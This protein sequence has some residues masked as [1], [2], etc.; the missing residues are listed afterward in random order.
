MVIMGIIKYTVAAFEDREVVNLSN[1]AL[2]CDAGKVPRL[3]S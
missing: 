3:R 1:K 2:D